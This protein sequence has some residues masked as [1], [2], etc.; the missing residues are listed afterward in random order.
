MA[1]HLLLTTG[2]GAAGLLEPLFQA[3]K[4]FQHPIVVF[5][6]AVRII[7]A[8]EGAHLQ[9]FLHREACKD[10]STL[11]RLTHTQLRD[12]M[13]RNL[14]DAFVLENDFAKP[15]LQQAADGVERCRLARAIG[16][17]QRDDLALIRPSARY[18]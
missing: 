2:E 4:E 5:L 16:A 9:V 17:D 14:V 12:L 10:L 13:G 11:G 15:W 18:P 7:G 1:K 8:V 6:D 3:G